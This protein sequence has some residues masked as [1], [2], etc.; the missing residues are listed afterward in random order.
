MPP[1]V[2]AD[3]L[4]E[5]LGALRVSGPADWESVRAAYR[6]ELMA[7]HP[8]HSAAA[9][10]DGRTAEIVSAFR[11]LREATAD[12]AV[13]LHVVLADAVR[14]A[15][16]DATAAAVAVSQ[17]GDT[18]NS[19]LLPAVVLT[20][21]SSDVW[22]RVQDA[23]SAEGDISGVDRSAG[24]IQAVVSAPGFAPAQLTAEVTPTGSGDAQ[25]LFTLEALGVGD[26]PPLDEV[27][28]RL[29]VRLGG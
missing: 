25:V 10:A 6:D 22:S 27:V 14:R 20:S 13:A 8:D 12:G 9:D 15:A 28:R 26:A 5:A 3:Q 11:L 24:L 4:G 29:G 21:T 17:A 18:E 23:M 1:E 7:A 19:V 2:T 16:D